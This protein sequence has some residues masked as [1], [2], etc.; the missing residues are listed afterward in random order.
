MYVHS[1]LTIIVNAKDGKLIKNC[2]NK[3]KNPLFYIGV[4][5]EI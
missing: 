1:L 4:E 3:T 5:I 2:K